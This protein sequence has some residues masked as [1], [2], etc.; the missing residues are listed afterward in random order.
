M[1]RE[2]KPSLPNFRSKTEDELGWDLIK[3]AVRAK[4]NLEVHAYR[5]R[6]VNEMLTELW[7]QYQA[8]LS[9]ESILEL[10][11]EYETW[12]TDAIQVATTADAS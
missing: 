6:R 4:T 10:E 1:R 9:G 2:G 11:P 8:A 12:I 3:A 5:N 7:P